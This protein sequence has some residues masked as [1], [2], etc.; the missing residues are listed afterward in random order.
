MTAA[1]AA[2]FA[3]PMTRSQLSALL[4]QLGLEGSGLELA[5]RAADE[6]AARLVDACARSP[7][8][9]GITAEPRRDTA[10]VRRW[11]LEAGIATSDGPRLVQ[12]RIASGMWVE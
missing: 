10:E 6:Y 11:A 3:E 12:A 9:L 8:D 5:L 2:L 4:A 1:T 7:R